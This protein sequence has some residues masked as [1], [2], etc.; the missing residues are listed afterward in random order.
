[1][2]VTNRAC[3]ELQA[4]IAFAEQLAR[5]IKTLRAARAPNAI[6][7]VGGL[8]GLEP[9]H[10]RDCADRIAGANRVRDDV[11]GIASLL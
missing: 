5:V 2:T 7:K 11:C 9:E 4:R 1:M 6:I 3:R 8:M 10:R